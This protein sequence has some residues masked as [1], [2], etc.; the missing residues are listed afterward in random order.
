MKKRSNFEAVFKEVVAAGGM[1]FAGAHGVLSAA[2]SVPSLI[3]PSIWLPLILSADFS[4]KNESQTQ[5]FVGE[6]MLMF[7]EVS[8]DLQK[9]VVKIPGYP[10]PQAVAEWCAGYY[11]IIRNDPIYCS[12]PGEAIKVFFYT[13]VLSGNFSMLGREDEFGEIIE[14]DT[15]LKKIYTEALPGEVVKV[16]EYWRKNRISSGGAMKDAA[17]TEK[18]GR[19][20]PCPCGSGKKFKKCCG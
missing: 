2:A 19:N 16:H 18:V 8:G 14:D 11:E 3:P 9:G 6:L 20:A 13:S 17:K 10:E 7:N 5:M 12:E 4:F 15:E 1:S